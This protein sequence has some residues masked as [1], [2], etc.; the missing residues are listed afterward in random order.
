MS[1]PC[2]ICCSSVTQLSRESPRSQNSMVSSCVSVLREMRGFT[3]AKLLLLQVHT[4][5]NPMI[6]VEICREKEM[7]VVRK[8]DLLQLCF[9]LNFIFLYFFC[10]FCQEIGLV[11]F[12]F[13]F[14][15]LFFL[16]S[17]QFPSMFPLLTYSQ[18]FFS[19]SADHPRHSRQRR[20]KISI[21]LIQETV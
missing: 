6:V 10:N 8:L 15:L 18:S 5:D 14:E 7:L 11:A 13:F 17:S 19:L 4:E 1:S 3:V 20:S 9:S 16:C 2:Q 12:M 21:L